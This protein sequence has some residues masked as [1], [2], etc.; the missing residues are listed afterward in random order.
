MPISYLHVFP[1]SPRKGT[2]AKDFPD[3]IKH[4]IT[5]ERAVKLRKLGRTKSKK[6]SK[7][8]IGDEFDVIIEGWV[9]KDKKIVKGLSDN[10][11]KIQFPLSA[12]TKREFI[13]VRIVEINK[14]G[15]IGRIK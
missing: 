6:F 8:F 11:L 14:D 15:A 9:S 2:P 1:Y 7:S 13:K 5:K 12:F 10:Y 3:Q 4:S